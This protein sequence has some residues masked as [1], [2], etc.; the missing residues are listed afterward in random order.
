[1]YVIKFIYINYIYI[2]K[3][4]CKNIERGQRKGND[5]Y[6]TINGKKVKMNDDGRVDVNMQSGPSDND[7]L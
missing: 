1:M 2:Y 6:V 4:A 5:D 7:D 3:Q